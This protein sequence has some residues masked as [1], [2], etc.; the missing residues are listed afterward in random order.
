MPS[1]F[2]YLTREFYLTLLFFGGASVWW[3]HQ[4]L[5]HV[6]G[7]VSDKQDTVLL[8]FL[9]IPKT[10][11]SSM[12]GFLQHYSGLLSLDH[13]VPT[14]FGHRFISGCVFGHFAKTHNVSV[15]PICAHVRFDSYQ[16]L[17]RDVQLLQRNGSLSSASMETFTVI[18]EPLATLRSFFHMHRA[19]PRDA[20]HTNTKEQIKAVESG[21]FYEWIQLLHTQDEERKTAF[22]YEFLD[23]SVDKATAMISGDEPQ[24]MVLLNECY[25]E[26][27][28]Y[29]ELKYSMLGMDLDGFLESR[30]F[31]LRKGSNIQEDPKEALLLKHA[32]VWFAD[33]FKFYNA[34]VEQFQKQLL[35]SGMDPATIQN[36]CPLW[37]TII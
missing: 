22:Q 12:M 16:E 19:Y 18:R 36:P 29:L 10:G 25:E 32:K 28:R 8:A 6:M 3:S 5:M 34:V 11:S 15:E 35:S 4:H 31:H 1:W 7:H 21:D 2:N 33:E 30:Y 14:D 17:W 23:R 13:A 9:R 37:Q 20:N 27:M 26:S 24:V